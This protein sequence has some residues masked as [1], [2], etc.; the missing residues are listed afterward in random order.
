MSAPVRRTQLTDEVADRLRTRII[1][2]EVRPG[3]FIRLD[4]AAAQR[5]PVTTYG[6]S[7]VA[8]PSGPASIA[9]NK[10]V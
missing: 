9:L 4:E 2:G 1:T 6:A 3:E 8:A 10:K 7:G 5:A